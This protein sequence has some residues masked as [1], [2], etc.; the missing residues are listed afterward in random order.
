MRADGA[1]P[2]GGN[3]PAA[4]GVAALCA[5]TAGCGSEPTGPVSGET[6][7]LELENLAVTGGETASFTVLVVGPEGQRRSAGGIT[8][9]GSSGRFE[10]E[11]PLERVVEVIVSVSPESGSGPGELVP[12]MSGEFDGDR[13]AALD[14]RGEVTAG[15]SIDLEREPGSH[16]LFTPSDNRDHG[17]P[18]NED[19]GI[20]VFNI[21]AAEKPARESCREEVRHSD[22]FLD[23]APLAN[24]WTYEGWVVRDHGT[25]DAVWLSYGKFEPDAFGKLNK[26]DHTGLGPFSGWEEFV[27]SP[28]AKEHCFPGDDWVQ[29]P[30]GL[31]LPAGLEVPLDL[32]GDA[33]RGVESR[34]TNVMTIEPEYERR[35]ESPDRAVAAPL[36]AVPFVIRPYRNE[37]GEGGA[38]VPRTIGFVRERVPSGRA[39]LR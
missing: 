24:G 19:G 15:D 4:I 35:D 17:Y 10:L 33:E 29:N 14:I 20:W 2:E 37:I 3:W 28:F 26:Q 30:F 9:T 5:L 25:E 6:L 32:N 38:D 18:S 27:H 34:W 21:G 13:T 36:S 23:M 22:F 1:F 11:N 7:T 8:A 16:V 31:E 39:I 12:M